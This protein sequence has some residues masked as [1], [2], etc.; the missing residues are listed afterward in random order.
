M[1]NFFCKHSQNTGLV[2]VFKWQL[3]YTHTNTT[4]LFPLAPVKSSGPYV[5]ACEAGAGTSPGTFCGGPGVAAA[6]EH[7]G[8]LPVVL[9][10]C[11]V[12]AWGREEGRGV[13]GPSCPI[14]RALV[15]REAS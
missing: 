5:R 10:T 3:W 11:S 13:G 14:Q 6:D 8:D 1:K 4:A 12:V 7:L 15:C 2:V 9:Q